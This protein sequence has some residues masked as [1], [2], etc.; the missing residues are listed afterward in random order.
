[1]CAGTILRY[2]IARVIFG[3]RFEQLLPYVRKSTL[4]VS[5]P[6]DAVFA[7]A[8]PKMKVIAGV[9]E[10]YSKRSFELYVAKGAF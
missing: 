2:R 3:M 8:K 9:L 1:M 7:I 6:S 4:P 5:Y 10:E